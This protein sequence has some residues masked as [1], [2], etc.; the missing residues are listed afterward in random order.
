MPDIEKL[1]HIRGW[2]RKGRNS[3][4]AIAKLFVLQAN[5]IN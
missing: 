1:G 5:A 2:R 3:R 4:Q